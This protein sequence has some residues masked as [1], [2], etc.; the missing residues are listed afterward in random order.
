MFAGLVCMLVGGSMVFDL[1]EVSDLT[2]PFWSVLVPVV[3][4]FGVFAA[5]VVFAVGRTLLLR[6][7]AGVDELIGA[8]GRV[9]GDLA[10]GDP[11]G[12]VFIRGE[13][14]SAVATEPIARG[15]RVEVIAVEGLQLRVRRAPGAA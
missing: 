14:W 15:A 13:Y 6:Q 9:V 10:P 11:G 5:L 7:T 3:A 4:A 8:M 2:V 12:K 1:P